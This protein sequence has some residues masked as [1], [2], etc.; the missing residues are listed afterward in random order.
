MYSFLI[1][2]RNV[3][4]VVYGN[5]IVECNLK[6]ICVF[7][8]AYAKSRF[9]HDEAQISFLIFLPLIVVFMSTLSSMLCR[10]TSNSAGVNGD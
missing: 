2:W 9:S 8:F 7:V 4:I 3:N 10:D 1:K 6:L 5:L